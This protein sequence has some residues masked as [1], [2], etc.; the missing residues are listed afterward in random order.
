MVTF[1]TTSENREEVLSLQSQRA[2]SPVQRW[3]SHLLMMKKTVS[4]C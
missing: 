1:Q 4:T 2:S 3:S